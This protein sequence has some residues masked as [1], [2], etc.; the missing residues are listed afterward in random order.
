MSKDFDYKAQSPPPDR[1][2]GWFVPMLIVVV[3]MAV[4]GGGFLYAGWKYMHTPLLK[5][6]AQAEEVEVVIQPGQSFQSLSENLVRLGCISDTKR[7]AV[8]AHYKALAGKI[9]TGRYMV[10]TG[11]SPL[12]LLTHLTSGKPILERITIPEGLAW[13]DV[14]RR[15]ALAGMVRME[16]FAAVIKDRQFLRHW[17]IPL[18]TAEGFLFPDTYYIMRPLELNIDSAKTIVGRLIDNFWRRTASLWPDNKRPGMENAALVQRT[19]TL[20]SIVEKE[21]AVPEERT[22]VAGV[23]F[24]RLRVGMPLQADPTIIYGIGPDF[25]GDIKRSDLNN[26]ENLYNTYRH[27]GLTPGPICSPGLACLR[28]AVN[29]EDHNLF[30][31]VAR[32]DGSHTFSKNLREHNAAVRL[33]RFDIRKGDNSLLLPGTASKPT[34]SSSA[35]AENIPTKQKPSTTPAPSEATQ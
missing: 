24:N 11:W 20:A 23:F 6:G 25:S 5:K 33:Y 26:A 32:G 29:P 10:S 13:W 8:L 19:V 17:G 1:R 4:I 2:S 27:A 16:D 21:T 7:F 22:R 15:L 31:F 28:A 12:Q 14:G 9:Q 35:P 3:L 18:P 30:Y 34:L